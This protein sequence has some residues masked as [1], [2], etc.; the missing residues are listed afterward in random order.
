MKF[1][2][3]DTKTQNTHLKMSVSA[4]SILKKIIVCLCLI[5]VSSSFSVKHPVYIGL[6]DI[7]QEPK[8]KI[9]TISL[10]LFT[11]DLEIALKK[12]VS[13]AS[14]SPK[15]ID[16]LHP[17]NKV[18]TDTILYHYIKKHLQITVNDK[19]KTLQYVGYEKEE[20]SV[21]MYLEIKA[22][23]LTKK[24]KIENSL[25]YESFANQQHII[26]TEIN[27]VK[28]SSKITNPTKQV[29]FLF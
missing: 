23:T 19:L 9:I 3:L 14:A 21:W 5:F 17:K 20:E 7:K 12:T 1:N 4:L 2:L 8:S 6:L 27:S 13:N 16:L 11:N 29:L 22:A 26:H 28:K 25:L 18:E 10:R 24:I 15:K